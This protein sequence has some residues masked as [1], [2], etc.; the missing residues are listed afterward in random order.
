[1][2]IN[3]SPALR[4][5][6]LKPDFYPHPVE[7][8]TLRETHISTVFLTGQFVYKIKKAVDLGFLDFSSLEKRHAGCQQELILNRRL[9]SGVY[10]EILP[11][12]CRDHRYALNGSGPVVEFAVKMHQLRDRDA[13]SHLLSTGRFQEARMTGLIQRL[14]DFYANAAID[15]S[16]PD[17]DVPAWQDNLDH[18]D[19]LI[20]PD[21]RATFEFVKSASQAFFNR[22]AKLFQR[23]HR[24]GRIRDCHGDLRCDHIYFTDTGIQIIDCIEFSRAL[25]VLDVVCDLAFLAMDLTFRGRSDLARHLIRQYIDASGDLGALPLLDFYCCYRAMV[26]CKVSLLRL[27]EKDVPLP[28]RQAVQKRPRA[29]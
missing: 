2:S 22:H 13:M 17:A 10:L 16:P 8:V 25:R 5:A 18:V 4:D 1:M 14:V 20:G 28:E 7:T 11:I 27:C 24:A 6:M 9:S 26:R 3:H 21:A 29:P 19:R 15:R 23:R 12:T